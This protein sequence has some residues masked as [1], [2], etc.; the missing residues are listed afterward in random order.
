MKFFT[1]LGYVLLTLFGVGLMALGWLMIFI[2][3]SSGTE[4]VFLYLVGLAT[5]LFGW[6]M[7]SCTSSDSWFKS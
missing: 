7:I 1:V 2:S 6:F 5:Y 3:L 4:S